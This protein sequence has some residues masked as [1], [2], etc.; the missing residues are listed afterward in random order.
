MAT[1]D[2]AITLPATTA[3]SCDG[4]VS[5][6]AG[7]VM[8]AVATA[9]LTPGVSRAVSVTM[10]ASSECS[11]LPEKSKV[12]DVAIPMPAREDFQFHAGREVNAS[13]R[14]EGTSSLSL[15]IC[16]A[17]YGLQV[18]DVIDSIFSVWGMQ[19]QSSGCNSPA[20]EEAVNCLNSAFQKL[21]AS[22]KVAQFVQRNQR[23]MSLTDGVADVTHIYQEPIT[24]GADVQ[25]VCAPVSLVMQVPADTTRVVIAVEAVN[26]GLY[27]V[28]IDDTEFGPTG[29]TGEGEIYNDMSALQTLINASGLPWIAVIESQIGGGLQLAITAASAGATP[30][31]QVLAIHNL[32]SGIT[33]TETL[34]TDAVVMETRSLRPLPN[35]TAVDAFRLSYT[36]APNAYFVELLTDT[37]ERIHL[38]PAP[39]LSTGYEVVLKFDVI[40]KPKRFSCQFPN[41]RMPVA[42]SYVETLLIPLAKWYA[43][44]SRYFQRPEIKPSIEAQAA[45]V[46]KMLGEVNPLPKE[47]P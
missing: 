31:G 41:E 37:P 12:Y 47:A 14:M 17:G 5:R 23:S 27:S 34:G 1:Y 11:W 10:S 7:I 18:S 28:A 3:L 13:I 6:A 45:E 26:S 38:A 39:D 42:H 4:K 2:V 36:T 40:L 16:T 25:S 35:R 32:E 43:L 22:G 21:A 20:G 24:V 46:L 33:V 9:T 30:A 44:A 19:C 8:A 29:L 15:P